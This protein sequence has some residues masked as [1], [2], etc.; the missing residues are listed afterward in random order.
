MGMKK[1]IAIV[2]TAFSLASCAGIPTDNNRYSLRTG[3]GAGYAHILG[4]SGKTTKARAELTMKAGKSA[5]VGVRVNAAGFGASL[6]AVSFDALGGDLVLREYI[7]EGALRPFG[8]I[9]A[10]VRGDGISDGVGL[11]AAAGIELTV[12]GR[13][14]VFLQLEGG[15]DWMKGYETDTLTGVVGGGVRF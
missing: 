10:G 14:F 5:E 12:A 15:H 9:F 7:G 11:G 4:D 3:A 6:P 1:L 13:G 2:A 8:E